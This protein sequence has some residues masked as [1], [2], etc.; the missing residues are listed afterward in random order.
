MGNGAGR[1]RSQDYRMV[2]AS[3]NNNV[4]KMHRVSY[5]PVTP[6]IRNYNVDGSGR[7]SY[8]SVNNGGAFLSSRRS[9]I[10]KSCSNLNAG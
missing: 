6:K 10:T 4:Y 3:L 5:T 2:T 1:N 8:I 7:D 9:Q